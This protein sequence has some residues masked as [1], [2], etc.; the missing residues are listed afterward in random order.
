METREVFSLSTVESQQGRRLACERCR[1][2]KLKCER[3]PNSEACHRCA[4]ADVKCSFGTALPPGRPRAA[5]TNAAGSSPP[6]STSHGGGATNTCPTTNTSSCT[7]DHGPTSPRVQCP[8]HH[9][10]QQQHQLLSPPASNRD[11][12]IIGTPWQ[13]HLDLQ[14]S[15]SQLEDEHMTD[16]L[17]EG[18]F[19]VVDFDHNFASWSATD[20]AAEFD[21][22]CVPWPTV[23][24]NRVDTPLDSAIDI[25]DILSVTSCSRNHTVLDPSEGTSSNTISNHTS[26]SPSPPLDLVTIIQRVTELGN[27]MHQL[28]TKHSQSEN[29][30]LHD[31]LHGSFPV[32]FAG[33]VLQV[34]NEFLKLVRCFFVEPGNNTDT[35][36]TT[37]SGCSS[38][39]ARQLRPNMNTDMPAAL[40]LIASHQRLLDLY[41]LFYKIVYEYLRKTELSSRQNQPIWKDLTLGKAPLSQF[42]DLHIKLVLQVAA[43]VLE[44]VEACLGLSEGCRVSRKLATE[45]EGILSTIVTSQF[46]E[47]CMA[48]GGGEADEPGGWA[49]I[50]RIRQVANVLTGMLD[51]PGVR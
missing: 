35:T 13:E 51:G 8:G 17:C 4:K 30:I 9:H 10:Q 5:R 36:A 40:Q 12:I 15:K 33:E 47:M 34:A 44:D 6:A 23:D 19:S 14:A 24:G 25:T 49:A 22:A 3:P 42:P 48:A 27:T 11:S 18:L 16:A 43:R 26:A 37:T 20:S 29:T 45:R 31:G 38:T 46:V 7:G 50:A 41:R 28:H 32:N 1:G 2:Q 39:S 21:S